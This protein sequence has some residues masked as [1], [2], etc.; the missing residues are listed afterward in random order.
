[1]RGKKPLALCCDLP[2]T[3]IHQ[4]D[5]QSLLPITNEI[6]VLTVA[7]IATWV[8]NKASEY[9]KT[10]IQAGGA[11]AGNAVGGVGGLIESSDRSLGEGSKKSALSTCLG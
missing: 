3:P 11:L 7:F 6:A 10:G 2:A 9:L 4:V 8:Q 5:A 1:M